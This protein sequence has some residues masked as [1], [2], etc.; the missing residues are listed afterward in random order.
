MSRAEERGFSSNLE[1]ASPDK[2]R[3][4]VR[5]MV[6]K[7]MDP[8]NMAMAMV[9]TSCAVPDT[10][11]TVDVRGKAVA[12]TVTRTPFIPQNYYRG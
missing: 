5:A 10:A 11:L 3:W 1:I 6:A 12:V 7:T 8:K 2:A 9:E 4:V